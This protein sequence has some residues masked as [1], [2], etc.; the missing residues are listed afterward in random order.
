MRTKIPPDDSLP[1]PVAPNQPGMLWSWGRN[2][3]GQLGLGHSRDISEPTWIEALGTDVASAAAG[4]GHSICVLVSGSMLTWGAA[5]DGKLGHG[6][7]LISGFST[8]PR[9]VRSKAAS[10]IVR[11]AAGEQ[12]SAGFTAGGRCMVFGSGWF[13]KLGL[14]D[15]QNA[16]SP[17]PVLFPGGAQ[18]QITH[19]RGPMSTGPFL[20][21]Y[22][23]RGGVWREPFFRRGMGGVVATT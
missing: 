22:V 7:S 11:V 6:S 9:E 14:G 20:G 17:T 8:M 1:V 16:Y 18:P 3:F 21:L 12:H 4:E 23:S 2:Q 10:G 5:E 19:L 15:M 13:G